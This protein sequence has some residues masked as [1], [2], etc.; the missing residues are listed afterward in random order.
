[1][2][3]QPI[4]ILSNVVVVKAI[5]QAWMDSN[6]GESGGHEEGG[7]ILHDADGQLIVSRWPHGKSNQILIPPHENCKY[8]GLDIVVS[9]HTHPNTGEDYI[10]EPSISDHSTGQKFRSSNPLHE[11]DIR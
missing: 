1:M 5:Q 3:L 10:Q 7:F 4:D 9:F 8:N 2:P 11:S 6:P